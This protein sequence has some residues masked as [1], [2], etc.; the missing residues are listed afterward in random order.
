MN[1][2]LKKIIISIACA[3][4]VILDI[5]FEIAMWKKLA[6]LHMPWSIIAIIAMILL[7]ILCIW[8]VFAVMLNNKDSGKNIN[9][10]ENNE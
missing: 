9:P 4:F 7:Y 8:F 3:A 1:N 10:P 6:K 2:N 5:V